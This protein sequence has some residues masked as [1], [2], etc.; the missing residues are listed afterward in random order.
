MR[1]AKRARWGWSVVAAAMFACGWGGNQFTPL[2]TLYRQANGDSATVVDALLGA[3]VLGL[4][5][6]LLL[7]GP[8]S[9]RHGH[10][11]MVMIA[12]G[13]SLL[14]SGALAAGTLASLAIGRLLSGV[15]VGLGMA[16]GTT[17][18]GELTQA[19]GRSRAAGARRA[20]LALTAG[21]GIGAGVAGV[22][23]QW[24]P[25]PETLPYLVQLVFA[26]AVLLAVSRAP[27]PRPT[28]VA[29]TGLR[30]Q[31]PALGHPRFRRLVLPMAPWV[32]GA[33]GVAYAIVPQALARQVGH[34]ALIYAT[35]LS[36]LTLG[37]GVLVQPLARRLDDARRPRAILVG[38]VSVT[39]GIALAAFAVALG[40]PT[41]GILAAVVL[42]AAYGI[43]LVAG[44]VEVQR[45]STGEDRAAL[46]GVYYA[47]S[48]VGFLLPTA[49]S[50]AKGQLG[51]ASELGAVSLLALASTLVIHRSRDL[52][53]PGV[54]RPTADA[55][56]ELT[57]AKA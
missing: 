17:W 32:F 1:E 25:L 4:A 34:L 8:L 18:V 7:G 19:S 41:W 15:A 23:A 53:P 54:G 47:L 5:P 2:L 22:L 6:A 21:F 55:R 13:C 30:P 42:G 52:P 33:A 46:T 51:T 26:A 37:A 48:Y 35:A 10:R 45:I 40:S 49:L 50:V 11:R 27:A 28:G 9:G 24:G 3:Y 57:G 20:S 43:A 14:G 12:L 29:A 56:L 39:L 44:L 16:V 38:M 31:V 36:V